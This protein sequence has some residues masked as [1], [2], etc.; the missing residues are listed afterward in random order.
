MDFTQRHDRIMKTAQR[1]E[2]DSQK[3]ARRNC[4][5]ETG[6]E[7][8]AL[9]FEADGNESDDTTSVDKEHIYI[10]KQRSELFKMKEAAEMGALFNDSRVHYVGDEKIKQTMPILLDG[11]LS[12]YRGQGP[13]GKED[14]VQ[15]PRGLLPVRSLPPARGLHPQ[16]ARHSRL[17]Q[18]H[19]SRKPNR[20]WKDAFSLGGLFG[21]AQEEHRREDE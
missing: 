2:S 11:N 13:V 6:T 21:L 3:K 16:S 9:R 10:E 20:H 18:P 7:H 8:K 14:K 17:F 15:A 19:P 1:I 4:E 5:R 12:L